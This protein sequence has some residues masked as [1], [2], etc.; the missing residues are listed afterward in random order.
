MRFYASVFKG[1]SVHKSLLFSPL[2]EWFKDS[3]KSLDAYVQCEFSRNSDSLCLEGSLRICTA[4]DY[5]ADSELKSEA[6]CDKM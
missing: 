6:T 3:N 1:R 2:K 5:E 4:N